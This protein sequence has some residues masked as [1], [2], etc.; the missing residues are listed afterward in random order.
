MMFN[1]S[2]VVFLSLP[3]NHL[4][5]NSSTLM[6]NLMLVMLNWLTYNLKLTINCDYSSLST[7]H[8]H[9][10]NAITD[11]WYSLMRSLIILFELACGESAGYNQSIFRPSESMKVYN[12]TGFLRGPSTPRSTQGEL[13]LLIF[14]FLEAE[15]Y[16]D[17]AIIEWSQ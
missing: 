4:T 1:R 7:Q 5:S 14:N 12:L 2:I 16:L 8:R 13:L 10:I 11:W 3:I 9:T 15:G 6:S 17:F